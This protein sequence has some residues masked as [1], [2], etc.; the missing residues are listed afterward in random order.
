MSDTAGRAAL[1]FPLT[2][3]VRTSKSSSDPGR[4]SGSVHSV[5]QASVYK[6]ADVSAIFR[7]GFSQTARIVSCEGFN[8]SRDRGDA[9]WH[10]M[11]PLLLRSLRFSRH[12]GRI[13]AAT[14]RSPSGDGMSGDAYGE[15]FMIDISICDHTTS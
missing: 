14:V 2:M 15:S 9:Q 3:A 11:V 10:C 12:Y 8:A 7:L 6:L 1:A 5:I 4:L 13:L